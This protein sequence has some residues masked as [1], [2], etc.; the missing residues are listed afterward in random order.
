MDLEKKPVL[1]S[2][3]FF[4]GVVEDRKDPKNLG[5]VKVRI[6]GDH[7]ADKTKKVI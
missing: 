2:M 7:D 4:M 1:N 5:R 6:Y 3:I